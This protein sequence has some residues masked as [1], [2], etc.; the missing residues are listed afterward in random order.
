MSK[1]YLII[2]IIL[3]IILII[4]IILKLTLYKLSS[5][6]STSPDPKYKGGYSSVHWGPGMREALCGRVI[7]FL[8]SVLSF[9]TC[10]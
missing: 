2:L 7:L 10:L 5:D 4:L 8:T 3:I 9:N 6:S 1:S